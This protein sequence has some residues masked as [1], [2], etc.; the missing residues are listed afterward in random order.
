MATLVMASAPN[1]LIATLPAPM[2]GVRA[3]NEDAQIAHGH[4]AA[5]GADA[6]TQ[7]T[8]QVVR[9]W[10]ELREMLIGQL[11]MFENGDL[12]LQSND[13]N[14]SGAAIEDLKRGIREFDALILSG[15]E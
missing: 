6:S 5:G 13:L 1:A 4:P 12:K 14:V 2:S 8:D 15:T 11:G 9:R 10:R 7:T 3:P